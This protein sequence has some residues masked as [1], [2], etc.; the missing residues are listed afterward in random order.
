MF[1]K[2]LEVCY[3]LLKDEVLPYVMAEI[4]AKLLSDCKLELLEDGGHFT[5]EGYESFIQNIVIKNIVK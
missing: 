2:I 5:N 4:T 3:Q 1:Q